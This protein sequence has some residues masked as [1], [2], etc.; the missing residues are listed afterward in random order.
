MMNTYGILLPCDGTEPLPV[1][2]GDHMHIAGMVGG[3]FDAVSFEFN[4]DA[5]EVLNAPSGAPEFVAVGYV[6]DTGLVDGMPMNVMASIVFGREL[7]GPVVVVSGTSTNGEY[8]GD[9]HDIPTWFSDAVFN[10]GL[11]GAAQVMQSIAE[12]EMLAVQLAFEDGLFSQA[13]FNTVLH[14]IASQD[15]TY[16]EQ[17]DLVIAIAVT[18]ALGRKTGTI[19]KYDPA[20]RLDDIANVSGTLT[21][22]DIE[23]FFEEMGGDN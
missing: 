16:S 3:H 12:S 8:D 15:D 23:R 2:V 9:N 11:H 18:Y 1:S 21:D 22:A 5:L 14:M 4:S 19:A 10:G 20:V 13:E 6:N 17:L 7:F